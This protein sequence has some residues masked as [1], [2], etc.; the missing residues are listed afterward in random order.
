MAVGEM[1]HVVGTCPDLPLH[2]YYAV[3]VANIHAKAYI[4]YGYDSQLCEE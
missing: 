3:T 1:Q 2:Y 4:S